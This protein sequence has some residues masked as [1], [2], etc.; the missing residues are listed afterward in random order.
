MAPTWNTTYVLVKCAPSFEVLKPGFMFPV[1][2]AT[3][4]RSIRV[5]ETYMFFYSVYHIF[6][7]FLELAPYFPLRNDHSYSQS[8]QTGWHWSLHPSFMIDYDKPEI[9]PIYL[10]NRNSV[11]EWTKLVSTGA[12]WLTIKIIQRK[13][14][15]TRC[16]SV[17][18]GAEWTPRYSNAWLQAVVLNFS[19]LQTDQ[20]FCH[21]HHTA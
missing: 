3:P 8:L 21:V 20:F 6:F 5:L 9:A 15:R 10:S 18:N 19:F 17:P 4:L 16:Q 13:E 14:L 7:L 2:R 1:H 12:C 11:H